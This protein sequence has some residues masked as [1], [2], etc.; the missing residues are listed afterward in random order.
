MSTL[1]KPTLELQVDLQY[2]A[3]VLAHRYVL[4]KLQS[5]DWLEVL[6]GE[7]GGEVEGTGAG[8]IRRA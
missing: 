2:L 1:Q 5:D 8:S 3:D 4:V 7:C 6:G